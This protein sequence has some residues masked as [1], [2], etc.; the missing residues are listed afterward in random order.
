MFDSVPKAVA[1]FLLFIALTLSVLTY[2]S[3]KNSQSK[4]FLWFLLL[5]V[6]IEFIGI[7][8]Y[9]YY[10]DKTAGLMPFVI[11]LINTGYLPK[12]YLSENAWLYNLY[13]MIIFPLY[14]YYHYSLVK[15]LINKKLLKYLFI[16][17]ILVSFTDLVLNIDI[18]VSEKLMLT[19][20]SGGIFIL[21]SSAIYLMEV[22]KSDEILTFYK[23]LPFWITFGALI[24]YLTTIPVFLFKEYL[25]EF[26]SYNTYTTILYISNYILY[27]SFII[28]FIVNAVQYNKNEKL[29]INN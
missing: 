28:G 9:Y 2:K 16:L 15:G 18:F 3:Y 26:N 24:Y 22:L 13:R 20:I 1:Y 11:G 6:F 29:K 5:T 4:Y 7:A 14:V 8:Q 25:K 12:V 21:I 17:C 19:R 10:K 23:T 27:G